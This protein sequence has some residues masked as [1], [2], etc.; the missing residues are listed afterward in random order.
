MFKKLCLTSVS[1]VVFLGA[2]STITPVHGMKEDDDKEVDKFNKK[3]FLKKQDKVFFTRKQENTENKENFIIEF[4]KKNPQ[5]IELIV[6]KNKYPLCQP[7]VENEF[8]LFD[9]R[10][11]KKLP[12]FLVKEIFSYLNINELKKLRFVCKYF[13]FLEDQNP[14][15]LTS[16]FYSDKTWQSPEMLL[17]LFSSCSPAFNIVL[18]QLDPF[19]LS[20]EP[21]S[22]RRAGEMIKM[23]H[24]DKIPLLVIGF[25]ELQE[26]SLKYQQNNNDFSPYYNK[27]SG[28]KNIMLKMIEEGENKNLQ[29]AIEI[30][31]E[32]ENLFQLCGR[33]EEMKEIVNEVVGDRANAPFMMKVRNLIE[34]KKK[35]QEKIVETGE[36]LGFRKCK[37]EIGY[38]DVKYD[39][40]SFPKV[41]QENENQSLLEQHLKALWLFYELEDGDH[42]EKGAYF[43]F[44]NYLVNALPTYERPFKKEKS[45]FNKKLTVDKKFKWLEKAPF[46]AVFTNSP[47][48]WIQNFEIYPQ[49]NDIKSRLP[50]AQKIFTLFSEVFK[51]TESFEGNLM[52]MEFSF[53]KCTGE[54]KILFDWKGELKKTTIQFEKTDSPSFDQMLR[55]AND[56]VTLGEDEKSIKLWDLILKNLEE[57]PKEIKSKGKFIIQDNEKE[58]EDLTLLRLYILTRYLETILYSDLF[59]QYKQ[60]GLELLKELQKEEK[61]Y[62]DFSFNLIPKFNDLDHIPISI[63]FEK[64]DISFF[65]NCFKYLNGEE[66]LKN[67][68]K[69]HHL[70]DYARMI[71]HVIF[72][73]NV[74]NLE[75]KEKKEKKEIQN[76]VLMCF[77]NF[78]LEDDLNEQKRDFIK[79]LFSDDKKK[80]K[81]IAPK[82]F[83]DKENKE[84]KGDKE[85]EK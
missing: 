36:K 32:N 10:I 65:E 52:A 34:L 82:F 74:D 77:K 15:L 1:A 48:Q 3:Q 49:L 38:I 78:L 69:K 35:L 2:V 42:S 80:L 6:N 7:M 11:S 23:R 4:Q 67:C 50:E 53:K 45:V 79:K 76:Y 84:D 13:K 66:K 21:Y 25:E 46:W 68:F 16:L 19:G 5:E 18:D 12:V 44:E 64:K 58:I 20:Q 73:K 60:K 81:K 39:Y 43:T 40:S 75:K 55:Q 14:K 70:E 61:N 72:H 71:F 33:L 27:M 62:K 57:D 56:Y 41:A 83:E 54:D 24:E 22:M 26:C 29:K 17:E 63:Y 31:N 9:N 8:S 85:I 28:V 51:E 37:E 47:W 59:L 30:I